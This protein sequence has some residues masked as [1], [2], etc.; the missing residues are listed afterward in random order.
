MRWSLLLWNPPAYLGK[1]YIIIF[2]NLYHKA[3]KGIPQKAVKRDGL[4]GVGKWNREAEPASFY[5]FV[6]DGWPDRVVGFLIIY[7]IASVWLGS[8]SLAY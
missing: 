2:Q 5:P 8:G 1:P 3:K 4:V 7:L 6:K